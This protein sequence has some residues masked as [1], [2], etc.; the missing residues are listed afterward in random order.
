M[1]TIKIRF[2]ILN[3]LPPFNKL[4]VRFQL[5]FS[6]FIFKIINPRVPVQS[7]AWVTVC[8]FSLLLLVSVYV[9]MNLPE[10]MDFAT[11]NC[12]LVLVCVGP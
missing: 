4:A 3:F 12:S 6:I 7:W 10:N 9:F 11:L 1:Y 5:R 8:G 2:F